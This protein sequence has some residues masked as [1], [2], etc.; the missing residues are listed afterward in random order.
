ML[1]KMGNTNSSSIRR[2]YTNKWTVHMPNE[3]EPNALSMTITDNQGN[4][5]GIVP[6]TYK[7]FKTGSVGYYASGKIVNATTGAK[8]QVGCNIIKVGSKPGSAEASAAAKAARTIATKNSAVKVTS[9]S[10]TA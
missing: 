4:V 1:F 6:A 9:L 8:Y 5:L 2:C 7:E 3:N 10:P